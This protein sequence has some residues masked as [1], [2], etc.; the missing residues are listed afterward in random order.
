MKFKNGVVANLFTACYFQAGSK[1]P[2]GMTIYGKDFTVEYGLRHTVTITDKT[3]VRHWERA[4][5][6]LI[7]TD[8]D[9]KVTKTPDTEQTGLQD[10]AFID[11]IKSGDPSGIRSNYRDAL[12]SLKLTMAC[13]E[14]AATGKAINL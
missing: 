4:N 8:V 6:E 9:G 2:S 1:A 12:K 5:D 3:G 10:R 7:F 14:S 13:N 11:A